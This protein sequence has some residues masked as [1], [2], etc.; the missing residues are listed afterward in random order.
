MKFFTTEQ[1]GQKQS[2]TPEGFLLCQDVPVA[3]TGVMI[4]GPNEVPIAPGSDGL[5]RVTRDEEDVFDPKYIASLNGKSVV[6]RHPE[7]DV[8]PT[9]WKDYTVGIVMNP[10]RGEGNQA[11]LLLADLLITDPE[12]IALVRAGEM[13]EVS[14]GYQADYD[15]TAPGLGRQY[16]F[17]ANHV[18]LVEQ[19]RCGA[20]CSIADHKPEGVP[21]M[22][23]THDK[24]PRRVKIADRILR[25]FRAQDEEGMN[26]ALEDLTGDEGEAGEALHIHL[27]GGQA[28]DEDTD[29]WSKNDADHAEFRSRIEALEAKLGK[30][31]DE[32]DPDKKDDVK[33]EDDPDK[34]KE[35]QAAKDNEAQEKLEGEMQDEFP[36]EV[37][38]EAV[39]ANDSAYFEDS[40]QDT[41]ALAEILVPGIQIPSYDRA[42]QPK[43]TFDT[44]CKLR[45][46]ALDAFSATAEGSEM[47]RGIYGRLPDLSKMTCSA[48]RTLFRSA[49]ALKKAANTT[50]GLRTGDLTAAGVRVNSTVKTLADINKANAEKFARKS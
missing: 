4:Y 23:R 19:G 10:R 49:G 5:I 17:I 15:E 9:N 41:V 48:V 32:E 1:L 7:D 22:T 8:N 14:C 16:N 25:A 11:D 37:A 34:K 40:F 21:D 50:A 38:K 39:K 36:P 28:K 3:R 42:A 29:R 33:D 13:R 30:T 18:A 6:I 2:L 47:V 45:R 35:E 26:S 12:G 46:R 27:P 43:A 24:A 31:G 44:M 20:R